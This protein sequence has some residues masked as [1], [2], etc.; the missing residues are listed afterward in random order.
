MEVVRA[1]TRNIL[2][3]L[4]GFHTITRLGLRAILA[5]DESIQ[6]VGEASDGVQAVQKLKELAAQGLQVD[7]VLTETRE[8]QIDGVLATR[9]TKEEFPETAVLV[10]AERENDSYVIDA[11]HAGAGGYLFLNET[12]PELLLQSIH[13]VLEGSPQMTTALLRSAVDHLLENGR[14][15]LAERTAEAARL[16][17]REIDVLRL[18]GNGDTNKM[19]ADSLGFSLDTVKRHVRNVVAKLNARSRTHAA[20]IAAQAGLVGKPIT[21]SEPE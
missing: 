2:V 9:L 18:M 12:S 11:I 19:I 14:K 15:T 5:C 6:I 3:L 20:I 21:P 13:G 10:M 7:V 17:A 16:S 1:A 4:I 8:D